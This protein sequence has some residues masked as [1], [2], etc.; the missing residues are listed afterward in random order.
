MKGGEEMDSKKI[1]RRTF[2]KT[3]V[4][5]GMTISTLGFPNIVRSA[6][7]PGEVEIGVVHPMTGSAGPMGQ[8][9]IRGW[10]IA[11]DEI[12]EAGGIKSLGG[13]KIKTLLRDSESDPKVGVAETE[14]LVKTK[15]VAIVGAWNSSV[16]YACTEV[17]E[18]NR[19]PWIVSIAGTDEI[20]RR[21]FKYIFRTLTEGHR[22]EEMLA[23]SIEGIGEKTGKK[24]K[25]AVIMGTDDLMGKTASKGIK[26]TLNKFKRECVGDILY[27]INTG[28]LKDDITK[29]ADKKPDVWFFVSQFK[30]AILITNTL[31]DQKVKALGFLAYGVG[32]LDNQYLKQVGNL[33]ENFFA[34][35]KFDHDLNTEL[36]Q[37][38]EKKM[39]TRYSVSANQHSACCYV[40]AYILK[41][42]LERAKSLDRD[43]LREAIESTNLT[44]GPALLTPGKGVKYDQNHENAY[45]QDLMSQVIQGAWHT[46]WPLERK[47]KFDLIWPRPDW[48]SKRSWG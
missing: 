14:K 7:A 46:V 23:N 4:G 5:A 9:A 29:L 27:P 13:A 22:M 40:E 15:V 36:E 2:I 6:K 28:S 1:D 38:F 35:T 8:N 3:A 20:C 19:I 26:E 24:A 12:N 18:R 43:K 34:V 16:T 10:N 25:T 47:R 48:P 33:G 44:S 17:A 37:G 21:G 42:A 41:D 31:Y 11:V 45:A 32:F 39:K 30:D